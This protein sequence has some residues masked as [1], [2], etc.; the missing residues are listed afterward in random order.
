MSPRHILYA[1]FIAL[2]WG[3]NFTAI[4]LSYE[5]FTPFFLLF[6]R[7]TLSCIPLIFFVPRP[8]ANFKDIVLIA[9]F[10]WIGQFSFLFVGMY[11]GAP[12]GL[13]SLILQS[14]TIFT[15]ILSVLM[16]EYKPRL[17]EIIGIS[18]ASAGI[19][20][21]GIDRFHGGSYMGMLIVIPAAISV[22]VSNI[23]FSKKK[24]PDENPLSMI[25]WTSLVPPIPMLLAS[26]WFEGPEAIMRTWD[27]LT[28]TAVGSTLYTVY[29][30]TLVGTSL[31]AYLLQHYNPSAVVPYSLLIPIFGMGVSWF[32][33][34][35]HYSTVVI[36][37][38]IVVLIGLSIN[39]WARQ[40][41]P[42]LPLQKVP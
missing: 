41:I 37:F 4:K 21:I 30:S 18:I 7:F 10:L 35:E 28:L 22:S 31:W 23:L 27:K 11:M 13:T 9:L 36:C 32:M 14:Q 38:S 39:Q 6:I 34:D 3:S 1:V 15:M 25:V 2:I 26:L 16:I 8:K 12:A 20:G 24:Q 19:I 42:K 17:G 40:R 5:S 29:F 33:L